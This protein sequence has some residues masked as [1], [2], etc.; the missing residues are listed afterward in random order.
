MLVADYVLKSLAD[1]GIDTCFLVY[2]GA[3]ADL[4][5]AFTRQQ[6]M[7]YVVMMHEQASSFAAE[8]YAKAKGVPGLAMGTS[9]PGG[10]NMVTGIA[11]CYYDSVPCIFIT[12]QVSTAFMRQEGSPMRQVGFQESNIVD[13]V[14]PITKWAICLK[15]AK[16]TQY[17]M[18]TAISECKSGRPGPVLIDLP[19]NIQRCQLS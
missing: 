11:N 14:R 16:D 6:R 2:G 3:M 7:K 19:V 9:G 18:R 8:G 1:E 10:H 17:C 5:E 12:G 4:V 15:D 13:I